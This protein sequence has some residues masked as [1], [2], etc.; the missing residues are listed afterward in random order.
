[1]E[2]EEALAIYWLQLWKRKEKLRNR[3][4]W[5]QPILT[6]RSEKGL[7]VTPY[8]D[9]RAN[10]GKFFLFARVSISSC[11]ELEPNPICS[12]AKLMPICQIPNF[13]SNLNLVN[14]SFNI[15]FSVISIHDY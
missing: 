15:N 11:D 13:W 14:K 9:L 12:Y 7:F 5:I 1:M 3:I 10:P 6:D 8:A 4:Y 2:V